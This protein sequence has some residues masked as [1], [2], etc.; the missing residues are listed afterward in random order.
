LIEFSTDINSAMYAC[1]QI[2]RKYLIAID[3]E[4]DKDILEILTLLNEIKVSKLTPKVYRVPAARVE[5][6]VAS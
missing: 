1:Y 4:R 2:G 5:H 6:M 3:L